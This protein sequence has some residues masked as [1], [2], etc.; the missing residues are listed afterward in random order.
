[1]SAPGLAVEKE[2]DNPLDWLRLV[3][4]L[5]L[6]GFVPFLSSFSLSFSPSLSFSLSHSLSRSQKKTLN[7]RD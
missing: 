6:E 3:I 4:S 1:M 5:D 7:P 2:G